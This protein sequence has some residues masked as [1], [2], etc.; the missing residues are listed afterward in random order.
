[1]AVI[2][3]WDLPG[4]NGDYFYLPAIALTSGMRTGSGFPART[5]IVVASYDTLPAQNLV[6]FN[7]KRESNEQ[8][9][10]GLWIDGTNTRIRYVYN[11]SA[12]ASSSSSVVA[13]STHYAFCYCDPGNGGNITVRL[14]P[15]STATQSASAT[16][17]SGGSEFHDGQTQTLEIGGYEAAGVVTNESDAH[18]SLILIVDGVALSQAQCEAFAAD[19]LVEGDEL[20]QTYGTDAWFWDD[21]GTDV[22]DNNAGAPTLAGTVTRSATG[23]PD[24]PEREEPAAENNPAIS[25][26][27][28]YGIIFAGE[29]RVIITGSSFGTTTGI[30]G[31]TTDAL[32]GSQVEQ[33]VNSWSDTEISFNCDLGAL[34]PGQKY[35]FVTNQTIGTDFGQDGSI[36]ISV[37]ADPGAATIGLRQAPAPVNLVASTPV[38][39]DM[40]ALLYKRDAQE[41]VTY[42]ASGLPTGSTIN[43]ASGVISGTP[44]A[45]ATYSPSVTVTDGNGDTAVQAFSWVVSPLVV[46]PPDPE[47]PD[48]PSIPPPNSGSSRRATRRSF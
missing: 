23:G 35:L 6:V 42:S 20:C 4:T 9:N 21:S 27:G 41:E 28:D 29:Q 33:D 26:V 11:A 46:D 10:H 18:V 19:P 7:A 17:A 47:D 48:A 30:V 45:A 37:L 14:I 12:V 34:S 38:S 43:S 24:V 3:S 1:M 16:G 2:G 5:V 32:G 39:V 44:S 15:L 40:G 31:L 13:T 8:F 22:G 36:S 25:S